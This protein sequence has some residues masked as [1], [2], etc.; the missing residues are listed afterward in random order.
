MQ[1]SFM[2]K[3]FRLIAIS[4][5]LVS[6]SA[7]LS[8]QMNR[9][10]QAN[11]ITSNIYENSVHAITGTILKNVML[12]QNNSYANILSDTLLFDVRNFSPVFLYTPGMGCFYGDTLFKD[13]I[14]HIGAW[15][16]NHF[17]KIAG[18][19]GAALPSG[20]GVVQAD[21]GLYISTALADGTTATT[22]SPGDNSTDVATDAFVNANTS[23]K[24]VAPN[25][26]LLWNN[27][28]TPTGSSSLK[29][30]PD[31]LPGDSGIVGVNGL[32]DLTSGS[33]ARQEKGLTLLLS[34]GDLLQMNAIE[35]YVILKDS[36]GDVF[37]LNNSPSN[38]YGFPFAEMGYLLGANFLTVDS[39]HGSNYIFDSSR[40]QIAKVIYKFPASQGGTN[41]VLT[42][43][44]NGVL[45]WVAPSTSGTAWQLTGNAGT[46]VETNFIG[47]TDNKGL[48]FKTNNVQSGY[49]D[50]VNTNTSLGYASMYSNAT[51]ANNIAIGDQTLEA[52]VGGSKN[53]VVGSGAMS[54]G[55]NAYE[56]TAIGFEALEENQNYNNTAVGSGNSSF[57]T[58]GGENTS[59][60]RYGLRGNTTGSYIT[61]LGFEADVSNNNFTNSTGLGA[62]ST[63]TASNQFMFG[64]GS[65]LHNVFTG[66]LNVGGSVGTSGQVLT[67]QG[68]GVSPIWTTPSGGIGPF[69]G[70][71]QTNQV[72]FG[73]TAN[74][75]SGSNNLEWVYNASTGDTLLQGANGFL[76]MSSPNFPGVQ[77]GDGAGNLIATQANGGECIF[78][79]TTADDVFDINNGIGYYNDD[80]DDVQISSGWSF[81][82]DWNNFMLSGSHS[83]YGND[84]I[85]IKGSKG[86][87]LELD[88]SATTNFYVGDNDGNFIGSNP[89]ISGTQYDVG[90]GTNAGDFFE[91][92]AGMFFLD[93]NSNYIGTDSY[94]EG[95]TGITVKGPNSSGGYG[96]IIDHGGDPPAYGGSG[97]LLQMGPVS[98]GFI[99]MINGEIQ[100]ATYGGVD[101]IDPGTLAAYD[102]DAAAGAAGL[103]TGMIYQTT[104]GDIP[105]V[106]LVMIKQ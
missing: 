20:V 18:G 88:D 16:R 7:S 104:G 10:N 24:M 53:T 80:G 82:D 106:G 70:S 34:N 67:S 47:T 89:T 75:I 56:G 49:I 60:G 30:K 63:I 8:A 37:L 14:A 4:F 41:T 54:D 105:I 21:G 42:N 5:Q 72:A 86:S 22:Q 12:N 87:L 51:G 48:M 26:S 55:S 97:L 90:I 13:S 38:T 15:N 73:K 57:I 69:T 33:Q 1:S 64:N 44:G 68:S 3:Y 96:M 43:S 59:V 79:G 101:G 23:P 71:I 92:G 76:D 93:A 84:G 2:K 39:A 99:N 52:N 35:K 17:I 103:T 9:T 81:S 95:G 40:F 78:I 58:T 98:N 94:T 11:N 45:S 85:N 29:Y 36:I 32:I 62:N 25:L 50:I 65:I 91:I 61:T 100:L 27:S 46:V 19:K 6:I 83:L 102:D 66:D 31:G 74:E 77:I 28:G